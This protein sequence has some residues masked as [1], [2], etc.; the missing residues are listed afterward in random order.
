MKAKKTVNLIIAMACT[1]M[2]VNATTPVKGVDRSNLDPA[3]A[4]GEDFYQYACGGW[5]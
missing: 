2:A 5:M 4:P 1:A 3:T